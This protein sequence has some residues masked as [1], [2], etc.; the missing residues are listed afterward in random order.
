MPSGAVAIADHGPGGGL[1]D[2]LRRWGRKRGGTPL[3]CSDLGLY[4]FRFP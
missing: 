2:A 4:G 1:C 3:R